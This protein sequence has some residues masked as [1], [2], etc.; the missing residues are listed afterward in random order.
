MFGLNKLLKSPDLSSPCPF[1]IT[2]TIEKI[3]E[4]KFS[5]LNDLCILS[6]CKAKLSV[7]MEFDSEW[8][9]SDVTK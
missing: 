9:G 4:N 7:V 6:N 2:T 8:E 5:Q 1:Y 3:V